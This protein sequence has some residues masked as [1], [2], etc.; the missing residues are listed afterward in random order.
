M[1]QNSPAVGAPDAP[2]VRPRCKACQYWEYFDEEDEE[3]I[4]T[5]RRYPPQRIVESASLLEVHGDVPTLPY[6]PR[7]W[8]QPITT[9]T[10]WC[11]EWRRA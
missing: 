1:E 3:R 11:G 7:E 2:K 6:T 8:N 4:G 9:E 10:D 5:C